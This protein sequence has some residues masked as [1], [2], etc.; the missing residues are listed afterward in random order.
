MSLIVALGS[1]IGDKECFLELASQHLQKITPIIFKS[2]IY[3]SA[4]VDYEDQP[5]FYNQVIELKIPSIEPKVMMEKLLE[6][7]LIMGRVRDTDKGPR[8]IDL[9]ILFWG[10]EHI[11]IPNLC[12]PHPRWEQRSFVVRPLSELPFFKT[13][14]KCFKMPTSFDVDAIPLNS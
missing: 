9:D 8:V 10:T 5:D 2:R 13:L 3:K 7:E 6:I 4:A 11:N 1:N 12:A 14:E